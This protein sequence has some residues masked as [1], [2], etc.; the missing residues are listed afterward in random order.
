MVE[1]ACLE[2]RYT[3]NN[4][5]SNFTNIGLTEC[6][7]KLSFFNASG[8]AEPTKSSDGLVLEKGQPYNVDI[9]LSGPN[10]DK[11]N[12]YNIQFDYH[13]DSDGKI[14]K[15]VSYSI[16]KPA[17]STFYQY[18]GSQAEW[19]WAF[20]QDCTY[21]DAPKKSANLQLKAPSDM[22]II[23]RGITIKGFSGT[24]YD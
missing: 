22:D 15:H 18:P 24:I 4:V 12:L 20:P 21:E 19:I 10:A 13:L 2:N 1:G 5:L 7:A 16:G 23:I 14:H 6:S 8:G 17:E 3:G 11:L 9:E